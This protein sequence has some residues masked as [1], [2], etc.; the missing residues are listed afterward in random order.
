MSRPLVIDMSRLWLASLR[1]T[2]RGIERVDFALARQLTEE[3]T[4]PLQGL[5]WTPW[6]I[7]LFDRQGLA[8]LLAHI[9]TIWREQGAAADDPVFRHVRDWLTGR[10]DFE[11]E[12]VLFGL[13][14]HLRRARRA[15]RTLRATGV[16]A[17]TAASAIPHGAI[18]ASFGHVGLL[19]P[20]MRKLFAARPDIRMAAL[21]HDIVSI[22]DP[23]F[24]RDKNEDYF[25]EVLARALGRGSLIL[26]TTDHVRQ[27]I[28]GIRPPA[29]EG[30]GPRIATVDIGHTFRDVPPPPVDTE[31]ADAAYFL[32]CGTREPR[33]NHLLL[34]NIWREMAR[35]GQ[36]VPKLVMAGGHGWG[37]ELV[38]VTLARSDKLRG[39]IAH[40]E[41]LSSPGLFHLV[42]AARALLAP[43]FEEGYGLPIAEALTMGT[44]VV[45]SR[46][47]VFA[48]TTRNCAVLIDPLDG[49]AWQ[50]EI[51]RRA[52]APAPTAAEKLA[53]AERFKAR[54]AEPPSVVA[55]LGAA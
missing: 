22:T 23:H 51:Q 17:G 1:S 44:P 36:R 41:T 10:A 16:S 19:A 37:A 35:G 39:H 4:G 49:L 33:K 31:L 20:G 52:A 34:L 2:P 54:A 46:I 14:H 5:S 43:S 3:W 7:R 28:E 8:R 55:C 42:G 12:P 38:D 11:P 48:E 26:T 9:E 15:V 25:R 32:I 6:G 47:P 45:A 24:F 50:A 40:V 29:V 27:Q 18:L 53:L 30:E 21:I 13:H